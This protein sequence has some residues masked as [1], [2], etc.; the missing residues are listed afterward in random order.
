MSLNW[1]V[2]WVFHSLPLASIA[3]VPNLG[4]SDFSGGWGVPFVLHA[5]CNLLYHKYRGWGVES[6][7]SHHLR[8]SFTLSRVQP[9]VKCFQ[10]FSRWF[11]W[12][13]ARFVTPLPGT[14]TEMERSMDLL[15]FSVRLVTRTYVQ[16]PLLRQQGPESLSDSQKTDS[17]QGVLNH[18]CLKNASCLR[19]KSAVGA[20]DWSPQCWQNM[21]PF[22]GILAVQAPVRHSGSSS[23]H[24][25]LVNEGYS[26]TGTWLRRIRRHEGVCEPLHYPVCSMFSGGGGGGAW[27]LKILMSAFF[28][29]FFHLAAHIHWGADRSL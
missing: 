22:H 15:K 16:A 13:T 18:C 29:Y 11:M 14:M 19:C 17:P 25:L 8:F 27:I 20:P 21:S 9:K 23:G 5:L 26:R 28:I 10:K 6:T 24:I 12:G 1:I 7:P 2:W 3:G 4:I